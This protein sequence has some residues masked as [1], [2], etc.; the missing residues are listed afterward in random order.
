MDNHHVSIS[1]SPASCG[2]LELHGLTSIPENVAYG[3]ATRLYHPSRGSPAGWALWSDVASIAANG[4][5]FYEF[6]RR[7]FTV[8]PPFAT[9]VVENPLTGNP[10]QIYYW[11]I[12]HAEFRAWYRDERIRRM[13]KL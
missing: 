10:I 2:I 7:I 3:L 8:A 12:P 4:G 9:G 11:A 1:S 13:K 6:L 5:I